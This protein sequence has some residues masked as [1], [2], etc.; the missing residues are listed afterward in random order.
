M[1]A[2]EICSGCRGLAA[3]TAAGLGS[4]SAQPA[5]PIAISRLMR[6]L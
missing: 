5:P 6:A 3:L 4:A 1:L 2:K